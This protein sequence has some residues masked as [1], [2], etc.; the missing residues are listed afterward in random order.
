VN[1][2]KC[3]LCDK[4]FTTPDIAFAHLDDKH[5]GVIPAMANRISSLAEAQST[6]TA[7]RD[8]FLYSCESYEKLLASTLSERDALKAEVAALKKDDFDMLRIAESENE[9][10]KTEVA[11]LTK[12]RDFARADCRRLREIETRLR[13]ALRKYG[14]H[15]TDCNTRLDN[16]CSCG[17]LPALAFGAPLERGEQKEG[18]SINGNI[19]IMK[20]ELSVMVSKIDTL[21]VERDALKAEAAFQKSNVEFLDKQLT[22]RREENG[23]MGGAV[24]LLRETLEFALRGNNLSMNEAT[25]LRRVLAE[26]GAKE[27]KA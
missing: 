4:E 2:F 17:L 1:N 26:T 14:K 20:D 23:E 11:R 16:E 3:W 5:G 9:F 25:R 24:G 12:E 19:V 22:M 8:R 18:S 27:V 7:E 21:T 15:A 10:L 6:L 13:E